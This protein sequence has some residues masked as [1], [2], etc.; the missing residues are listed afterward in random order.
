MNGYKFSICIPTWNRAN[1]LKETLKNLNN[2]IKSNPDFQVVISDNNSND[3]TFNVVKEFY[4]SLNIK[5]IRWDRNIGGSKNIV[6]VVNQAD[7]RYCVLLGD[8]DVFRSGWLDSLTILVDKFNPDVICSDRI[9]CDIQ[10]N[11]KYVEKCGPLVSEP[12]IYKCADEEVLYKYL[13]QTKST[14]G[15]GFIS[16]LVIKKSAWINSI[17]GD[18]VNMHP[19]PHMIKILDALKSGG[20]LLRVPIETVYAR[21]GNHR[22]YEYID[23]SEPTEFEQLLTVHF[24]GFL[25]AAKFLFP[26]SIELKSALL[27]PIRKIFN[28]KYR[29]HFLETAKTNNLTSR[30]ENFLYQIDSETFEI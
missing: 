30:A 12:T 13:T 17:D 26:S 10:L 2:Q 11:P 25:S 8:D 28:E 19:F 5:Y 4:E 18:Y 24:E 22:L 6:S 1:L 27:N 23:N 9:V 20:V 16:N 3:D 21:T 29:V 14:S 15:F 7:G